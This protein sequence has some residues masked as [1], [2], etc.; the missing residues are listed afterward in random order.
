[1][2]NLTI[3]S[4]QY[5]GPKSETYELAIGSSFGV[6]SMKVMRSS[7]GVNVYTGFSQATWTNP[8]LLSGLKMSGEFAEHKYVKSVMSRTGYTGHHNLEE[9]GT[10][11]PEQGFMM[12]EFLT[13]DIGLEAW[14]AT[15]I[16][17]AYADRDPDNK[18]REHIR[19]VRG[20]QAGVPSA[21]PGRGKIPEAKPAGDRE[22]VH[23][24]R[25]AEDEHYGIF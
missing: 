25:I 4:V 12:P 19:M 8:T 3:L 11:D 22:S 21:R 17:R 10:A 2:T 13:G 15:A 7:R 5:D 18:V 24:Q 1:M 16:Q 9:A 6:V 20:A 14:A 23:Q